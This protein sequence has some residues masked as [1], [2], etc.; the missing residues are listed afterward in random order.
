MKRINL[1]GIY[2]EYIQSLLEDSLAKLFIYLRMI[3]LTFSTVV[4]MKWVILRCPQNYFP[5]ANQEREIGPSKPLQHNYKKVGHWSLEQ[6]GRK[7]ILQTPKNLN[8][9]A[10]PVY[11]ILK[12]ILVFFIF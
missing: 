3:E 1:D 8:F 10:R 5:L 9:S 11:N 2:F 12:Y 6:G 4:F 7:L